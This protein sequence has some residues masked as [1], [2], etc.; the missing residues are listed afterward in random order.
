[1][2]A[3]SDGLFILGVLLTYLA[4][5]SAIILGGLAIRSR[6]WGVLCGIVVVA[7]V[8]LLAGPRLA[9]STGGSMAAGAAIALISFA[10]VYVAILRPRMTWQDHKAGRAIRRQTALHLILLTGS[11]LFM[12]PFVWLVTTSLKEDE[13]MSRFPPVWIPQQQ[14]KIDVDGKPAGLAWAPYKG[15]RAKV[16]VLKEMETGDRRLRVLEPAVYRGEEFDLPRTQITKIKQ[17]DPVWKNYPD[18]LKFLPAETQKGLVFLGNTLAISLLTIIGTV[19]SCSLVAFSFARLRWPGRDF[20]FVVL[21][22]TMM[23]PGA[24]TMM[25]VFLINRWLGWVDTLRPLWFPSFV[26]A[27]GTHPS[28]AFTIFLLRQF[29]LTIPNDLEDAAK[30]DGCSYFGIYWRIMLPLIKPALAAVVIL[31]FMGS[32]NDFMGPLIYISSPTRMPLAYALQLFQTA[33][34]GEPGLLMAASTMMMLPV[35][36]LFFFTQRYFIQG[37]TL[38][39]IKG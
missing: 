21:L 29:F 24:V 25:P 34:G 18:A 2:H 17:F 10:L 35:L 14:I 12:V 36:A 32:W 23:I 4:V 26:A 9:G 8:S 20:L 16:A 3:V 19:L 5:G 31:K 38:T 11:V 13:D 15:Q 6:A 28:S 27:S 1:V 33:H 22:A 39:G 37:V 30:I 7:L